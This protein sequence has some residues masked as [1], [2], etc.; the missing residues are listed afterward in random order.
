MKHFFQAALAIIVGFTCSNVAAMAQNAAVQTQ[1]VLP[2]DADSFVGS[3]GINVHMSDVGSVYGNFPKLKSALLTL[4]VRHL[5]DG[6]Q[7][8]AWADFY[9]NHNALGALGI[10]S[11]FIT[12]IGQSPELWQS[13]PSRMNQCFEAYE[14]PNEMDD[15][16]GSNWL[17]E[18][19]GEMP[20]LSDAVRGKPSSFP[21]YGPSLVFQ[22]SF[23][24]LG[25]VSEYFDYGNL[26]NYPGG[27]NPETPGWGGRDAW[28]NLYGSM[29][30][31]LDL[32]KIDSPGLRWTTTETGYSDQQSKAYYVPHWVA[33]TYLPR[34]VL[35]NWAAGAKRTFIYELVDDLGENY[36]LIDANWNPKPDFYALANLLTLLTDRG[37]AFTPKPLT[38]G[39]GG[40]DSNLRQT[41]FQKRNGTYY[42]PLWLGESAYNVTTQQSLYVAPE[43]ITVQLPAGM[44][45]NRYQWDEWGNVTKTALTSNDL[46]HLS[47]NGT[48]TILEISPATN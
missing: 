23:S 41:L 26:H 40:G 25:N 39:I 11:I 10:K 1:T 5:R 19:L 44:Q 30:W 29:A 20:A 7:D 42:L 43:V 31:Q 35:H 21:V 3:I 13:F 12:S 34:L 15:G 9:A 18:L 33:A 2:A 47:I 6:L 48:L 16:H 4:G 36:G 46:A 32:M 38:F 14:N 22:Q 28:G 24:K 27:Q 37:Q 8:S 17:S 45:V